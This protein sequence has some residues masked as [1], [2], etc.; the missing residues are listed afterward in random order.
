MVTTDTREAIEYL[1]VKA[2]ELKV[3]AQT[4][5]KSP[6]IGTY[7]TSESVS[8]L[9]KRGEWYQIRVGDRAGWVRA[10][11]LG[12]AAETQYSADS[13]TP[14]FVKP[15]PAVP[16]L[17]AKGDIYIEADVNT[18]GEVTSV[19]IITNTTGNEGLAASNAAA[20]GQ[21]KFYPIVIKGERKPFKYYHRI[22]Y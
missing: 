15:P 18:S 13:P 22:T 8:V 5:E 14:R 9:E 17:T 12:T 7:Q 10:S 6:V 2:P 4:D 20:L 3:Y 11:G 19:K 16:N 1:Y 21:A